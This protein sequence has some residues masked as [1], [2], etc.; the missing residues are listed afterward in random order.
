MR[1]RTNTERRQENKHQRATP[2]E[3]RGVC[4]THYRRTATASEMHAHT[5]TRQSFSAGGQSSTL[6]VR[7]HTLREKRSHICAACCVESDVSGF[8]TAL[9]TFRTDQR[10]GGDRS[11]HRRRD[12][13]PRHYEADA[14]CG[15]WPSPDRQC[16]AP[17]HAKS[18]RDPCDRTC[19]S[20]TRRPEP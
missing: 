17:A 20:L 8:A 9:G 18:G 2:A 1:H 4:S 15:P 12:D 10:D 7:V 6:S 5:P 3:R 16:H 14:R 11:M 13:A 19:C